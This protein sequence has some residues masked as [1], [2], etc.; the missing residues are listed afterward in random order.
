MNITYRDVGK[1]CNEID[2]C[3]NMFESR[4][5]VFE[6]NKTAN[7]FYWRPKFS[8]CKKDVDDLKLIYQSHV[9]SLL[10]EQSTFILQ[11]AKIS[12]L[13]I[14]SNNGVTLSQEDQALIQAASRVNLK[15][16]HLLVKLIFGK[17]D[18]IKTKN[19]E[20]LN[21][22]K[23]LEYIRIK[24]ILQGVCKVIRVVCG[25]II[26]MAIISA[27][28]IRFILV[29]CFKLLKLCFKLLKLVLLRR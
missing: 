17:I 12:Q 23:S 29:L 19:S 22:C 8:E 18:A 11:E 15:A 21:Y 4:F 26:L 25:I 24:R 27:H 14:D 9:E 13:R 7:D 5:N 10:R 1:C 28:I 16:E 3:F 6:K 20:L 2:D